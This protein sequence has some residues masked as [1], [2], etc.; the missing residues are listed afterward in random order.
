MMLSNKHSP[1]CFAI[2]DIPLTLLLIT[3]MYM[4]ACMPELQIRQ[5]PHHWDVGHVISLT[6]QLELLPFELLLTIKECKKNTS[7]KGGWSC[8]TYSNRSPSCPMLDP[9]V[10][11]HLKKPK[12]DGCLG[13]FS[14][15]ET[16]EAVTCKVCHIQIH[17]YCT[18]IPYSHL[19]NMS[20]NFT[21][22]ACAMT[23]NKIIV[24]ELREEVAAMKK[25]TSLK[26]TL[27]WYLAYY[28]QMNLQR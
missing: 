8:W 9:I 4:Y 7:F 22:F 26:K 14:K 3:C 21:C 1:S 2:Q 20:P 23:A 25:I 6:L 18:G 12:C 16:L 10:Q 5:V 11:W 15:E 28:L 27:K 13:N 19:A 17:H 24:S